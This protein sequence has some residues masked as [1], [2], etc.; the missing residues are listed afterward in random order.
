MIDDLA[1]F[2]WPRPRKNSGNRQVDPAES[3][4]FGNPL[5]DYKSKQPWA[6]D[7]Q[8]CFSCRLEPLYLF[9]DRHRNRDEKPV[10]AV[11]LRFRLG[12]T[13]QFGRRDWLRFPG[14]SLG[15]TLQGS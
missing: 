10:A 9:A 5:T 14:T 8:G 1:R 2:S 12:T 13:A 6:D 4:L 15:C 7:A 3:S 11:N